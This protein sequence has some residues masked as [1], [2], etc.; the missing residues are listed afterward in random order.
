MEKELYIL[1]GPAIQESEVTV[2]ERKVTETGS[3]SCGEGHKSSPR[4]KAAEV[5]KA[6]D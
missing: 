6:P 2:E 3:Q 1:Q 5:V 4:V